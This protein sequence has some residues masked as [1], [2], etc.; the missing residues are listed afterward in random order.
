MIVDLTSAPLVKSI[1][2]QHK[3]LASSTFDI[4]DLFKLIY[5]DAKNHQSPK[6]KLMA[7]K[8]MKTENFHKTTL[9]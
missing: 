2:R 1:N 8:I 5:P 3:L 6:N 4:S 7:I 9:R